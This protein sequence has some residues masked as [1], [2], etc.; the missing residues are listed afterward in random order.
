MKLLFLLPNALTFL[1]LFFGCIAVVYGLNGDLKSLA[2]FVFLGMLC[3]FFDGFTARLLNIKSKIGAQLDSFSD[4]VTFGFS[5]SVVMFIL[6]SNSSFITDSSPDSY[7]KLIPYLSFLITISSSYRLANFNLESNDSYFIGLPTP[8]NALL[9]VFLPFLFENRII[10][11]YVHIKDSTTFLLIIVMLSSYLL[12]CNIK[13]FSIKIR[14]FNFRTKKLL[15]IFLFS[16]L[17]LYMILKLAVFPI[18]ILI[19]IFINLLRIKV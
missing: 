12:V 9:I 14:K 2:L 5:S 19:Y 1:N 10:T 15:F 18:I 8:A 3:D 17:F 6:L 7:I 4:L 16:F 13:M 11:E